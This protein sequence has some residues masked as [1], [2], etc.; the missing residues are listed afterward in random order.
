MAKK[1]VDGENPEVPEA[2]EKKSKKLLI[3]ILVF[4]LLLLGGG[5]FGVY[6]FFLAPKP[7]SA[8]ELAKIEAE[9]NKKPEI[10]PV[11]SLKP[12]VVNLADGKGRRYLKVSM[13]LE[14]SSDELLE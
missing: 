5:G 10:L 9:K 1:E 7:P 11:F 6:Y 8:E 13:K 12:F 14:L 4:V 3:I 2:G